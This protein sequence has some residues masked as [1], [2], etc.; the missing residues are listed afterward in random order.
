MPI[1]PSVEQS[2]KC[3]ILLILGRALLILCTI[4]HTQ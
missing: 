2:Y 3:L 4:V 1:R